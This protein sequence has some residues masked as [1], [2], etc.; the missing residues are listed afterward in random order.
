MSKRVV[1]KAAPIKVRRWCVERLVASGI[2]ESATWQWKTERI[3][4]AL[5]YGDLSHKISRIT[6]ESAFLASDSQTR[7]NAAPKKKLP[8]I[9]DVAKDAFLQ[10]Y[11]WRRLRMEAL[12]KYGP[13]CQ[14]CGASVS[15]GA[16]MNVDHIKPRRV[17]PELALSL[18]NLQILCGECNHG[19]G[20]W[21]MTD[22]RK[23]DQV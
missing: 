7:F 8:P 14:C 19:K 2:P 21:D 6:L 5:G 3:A 13:R 20:N 4:A 1:F 16:V 10:S 23:V 11:E 18:D 12:K 22:W 9:P 15:D 17:Y